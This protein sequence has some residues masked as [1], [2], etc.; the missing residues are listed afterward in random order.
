MKEPP[1]THKAVKGKTSLRGYVKF[2]LAIVFVLAVVMIYRI[3]QASNMT[4]KAMSEAEVD[5]TLVPD[6]PPT[7]AAEPMKVPPTVTPVPTE[8]PPDCP[9]DPSEW[10][11]VDGF[12][13]ASNLKIIPACVREDADRT[14]MWALANGTMGYTSQEAADALGFSEAPRAEKDHPIYASSFQALLDF[15]DE[16][17][18]F[19]IGV[20]WYHPELRQWSLIDDDTKQSKAYYFA[21]C[22]RTSKMVGGQMESWSPMP[23][24]C[25]YTVDKAPSTTKTLSLDDKLFHY[26]YGDFVGYRTYSWVGYAGNGNWLYL[27][28]SV[29]GAYFFDYD[30]NKIG[31]GAPVNPDD[32]G[33]V[34]Q[35]LPEGYKEIASLSIEEVNIL[36]QEILDEIRA[37]EDK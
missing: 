27:G 21:G 32:Y 8:V 13:P 12:V 26:G 22:F 1:F 36:A 7:E 25:Q 15:S 30:P 3:T 2:A 24:I 14:I 18:D 20:L 31:V 9:D 33:L 29:E 10:E 16:P 34:V 6:V 35:P 4:E 23:V 37:Y 28:E 11:F 5:T 17:Q 19:A